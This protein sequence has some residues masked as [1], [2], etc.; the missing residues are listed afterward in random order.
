MTRTKL[1]TRW[2]E[3][4]RG[5][6]AVRK[7]WEFKSINAM[8]VKEI[9]PMLQRDGTGI[10]SRLSFPAKPGATFPVHLVLLLACAAQGPG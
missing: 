6:S 5:E 4:K 2:R 8:P 1:T 3:S 7:F 10:T 9:R